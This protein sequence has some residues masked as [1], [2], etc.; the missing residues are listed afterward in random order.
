[1]ANQRSTVEQKETYLDILAVFHYVNGALS[2]LVGFAVLTFL[3]IGLGA[4]T[5]W[6]DNWEMEPGCSIGAII[7]LVLVFVGGYAI[8]NILTGRAL[9]TRNH[10]VL[11]LVTSALN[12]L[13]MPFGTLL[14]IF[15]L[16]LLSDG[17]VRDIFRGIRPAE[18]AGHAAQPP[19]PPAE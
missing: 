4:A 19:A 7:F 11:S 1:M 9:Q 2:A 13:N 8:L 16:V 18:P 3:G 10:Y 14:G 17:Q 5:E 15:T 12:C 6:G